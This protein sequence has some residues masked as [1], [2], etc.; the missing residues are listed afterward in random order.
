MGEILHRYM[1]WKRIK[2][3][4]AD[5][6]FALY[7]KT[8]ANWKCEFCHK[9]C[10]ANKRGFQ[11]SHYFG[12]AKEGTRFDEK[13]CNAFCSTCHSR[14]GHG[15]DRDLY[16][17]FKIKQLGQEGFDRLLLKSNS[18]QKR[19]RKLALIVA[20]ELLKSLTQKND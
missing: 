4:K 15:D 1:F 11:C 13:N 8:K 17:Q 18:Y 20:K 19:D 2:I 3:D 7:I 6:T 5:T 14:L 16:K 12:R 10:T 9:D